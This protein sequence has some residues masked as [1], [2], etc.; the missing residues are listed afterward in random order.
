MANDEGDPMVSTVVGWCLFGICLILQGLIDFYLY[1]LASSGIQTTGCISL[2]SQYL[3]AA[4]VY[5]LLGQILFRNRQKPSRLTYAG[6]LA[7]LSAAMVQFAS[8][9]IAANIYGE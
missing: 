8:M 7:V 5:F 9:T 2:L 1:H 4:F 6:I 3:L